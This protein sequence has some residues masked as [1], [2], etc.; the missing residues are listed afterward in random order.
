M[1]HFKITYSLRGLVESRVIAAP[2]V[3]K[4]L[5]ELQNSFS[6]HDLAFFKYLFNNMLGEKAATV[7]M[8]EQRMKK[9]TTY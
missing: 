7:Y 5:L 8:K 3:G 1:K 9:E 2:T 4:A 6:R